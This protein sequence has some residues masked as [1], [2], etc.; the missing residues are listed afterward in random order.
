MAKYKYTPKDIASLL[1]ISNFTRSRENEIIEDIFKNHNDDII[2]KY[3]KD[4]HKLRRAVREETIIL[5]SDNH[6]FSETE[7]ILKEFGLTISDD[8]IENVFGQYFRLIKLQIMYSHSGYKRLKLRSILKDFGYKRR[9][10][11]LNYSIQNALK[12]LGLVTY[13][14]GMEPCDITE[15]SLDQMVII[16]LK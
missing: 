2:A 16:R 5:E 15:I 1:C 3:R 11:K 12:A 8:N 4:F 13:L 14:K 7:I 6:T 9:S 10:D